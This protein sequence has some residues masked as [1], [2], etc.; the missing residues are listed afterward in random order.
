[1]SARILNLHLRVAV[2]AWC[3]LATTLV[4]AGQ[5]N[6]DDLAR[7]IHPPLHVA[8]RLPDAPV[9]PITSELEPD[10]DVV[11]YVFESIDLAPIP[12]FE[13]TPFDLLVALDRKG[14]FVDVTLLRQH[15]PVFLSGLGEGP[16]REFL[17]QYAGHNLRQH[18]TVASAYGGA[19]GGEDG[20]QVTLDGVTKATASIRI[21]NQTVLSA[22][23]AVARSQLGFAAPQANRTAIVREDVFERLSFESLVEKGYVRRLTLSNRQVE[24]MF[25]GSDGEGLDGEGLQHPDARFTDLYVAY[26][27]APTIGRSLLGDAGYAEAMTNAT[28]GQQLLWIACVGRYGT[29]DDEFVPGTAPPRLL[30]SQGDLPLELRDANVDLPPPPVPLDQAR[31]FFVPAAAG[32]DPASPVQLSLVIMRTRGL[33]YAPVTQREAVIEYQPP[34]T[35]FEYPP[36]PLPEWLLAWFGRWPDLVLEGAMLTVLVVLLGWP[37]RWAATPRRLRW[38]RTSY[39][40]FTLVYLGWYAQGQLSIVQVTG[41]IKSLTAGQGLASFLYDPISLL[42]IVFTLVSFLVWGRGTFCGWLCPFGAMQEF[43]ALAARW[44]RVPRLRF[45][46]SWHRRLIHLPMFLLGGLVVAAAVEPQL[47]EQGVEIEPFKTAITVGFDRSWPFVVYAVLLLAAGAFVYKFFC[48]YLCPLGAVMKLGGLLRRWNWLARRVECG[49]PCQTCR[50]YCL[51]QAIEAD[52]AVRYD[53]CFQC[54][55]CVAIYNDRASCAAT[56][57]LAR[58]GFPMSHQGKHGS[59]ASPLTPRTVGPLQSR[60]G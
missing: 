55:D 21:V 50:H 58:K 28:E 41:A 18:I 29:V 2:T 14:N 35:L 47:A 6:R 32:M 56:L 53:E 26:L 33:L 57:Y 22:A 8:D 30:L 27:N 54:L 46:A 11:G 48:R 36:E 7:F 49:T 10:A 45:R 44:L 17:R 25:A 37:R 59:P 39:L 43:V 23:L 20:N 40:A 13:G 34:A 42:L 12:G 60:S 38:I 16:L 5:L 4:A 52:G 31:V 19:R 1:M 9:W 15:E 24:R 3:L 51:Y